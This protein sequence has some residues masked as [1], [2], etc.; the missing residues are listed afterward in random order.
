MGQFT[1]AG[2]ITTSGIASAPGPQ[3]APDPGALPATTCRS[4]STLYTRK[5]SVAQMQTIYPFSEEDQTSD[6][7]SMAMKTVKSTIVP[8]PGLIE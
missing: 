3:R 5:L 1:D 7:H 2:S 6:S 8:W 4:A